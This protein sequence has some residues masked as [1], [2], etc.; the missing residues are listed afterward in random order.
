MNR[1]VGVEILNKIAYSVLSALYQSFWT[2]LFIAFLSMFLF[3]YGKE[4]RWK[5]KILHTVFITWIDSFKVSL[6]FRR[7][8][9][10]AFYTSMILLRTVLNRG[11]WTDPL[12]KI[13]GGW[14]LYEDGQLTTEAIENFMLFI[15]FSI[16]LLWVFHEKILG[17]K[18]LV[19]KQT[20]WLATKTVG[21]FSFIIEFAQL[22]FHIGTFQIS[23]LCY[24]TLGGVVGGMIYYLGV[25]IKTRKI[26][27][28]GD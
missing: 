16:L 27:R 25:K 14:G 7:I 8:F 21:I 5:E 20:I 24:N 19:F 3:L 6:T 28:A 9:Y 12:G 23:D 1:E 17:S 26:S 13:F 2:A 22:L 10:L 11:I 4:H 15:P 18:T